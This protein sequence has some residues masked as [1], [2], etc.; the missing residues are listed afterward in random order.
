[1]FTTCYSSISLFHQQSTPPPPEATDDHAGNR[2]RPCTCC[3]G[4]RTAAHV[5]RLLLFVFLRDFAW[6][7]VFSMRKRSE[8]FALLYACVCMRVDVYVCACVYECALAPGHM[9]VFVHVPK[10]RVGAGCAIRSHVHTKVIICCHSV[11]VSLARCF[12]K[13]HNCSKIQA[14]SHCATLSCTQFLILLS[15]CFPYPPPPRRGTQRQRRLLQSTV[16]ARP[17]P[18]ISDGSV[19]SIALRRSG[20]KGR[21]PSAVLTD[22]AVS[23]SPCCVLIAVTMS[24]P[25]RRSIAQSEDGF[26]CEERVR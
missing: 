1:M 25:T 17:R 3:R 13:R 7:H 24:A 19:I 5:Q 23:L 9:R 10:Q 22:L 16:H 15:P 26:K 14:H 6:Q 4:L 2:N 21:M 18:A 11:G 12:H 20:K 8:P